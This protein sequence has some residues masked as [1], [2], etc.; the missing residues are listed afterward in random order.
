MSKHYVQKFIGRSLSLVDGIK[1]LLEAEQGLLERV[2]EGIIIE[3]L[4]QKLPGAY[5]LLLASGCRFVVQYD[6]QT[7]TFGAWIQMAYEEAGTEDGER[8]VDES[9]KE[10]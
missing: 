5:T 6:I 10:A 3:P 4:P 7:D 8:L 2:H 1:N 9:S